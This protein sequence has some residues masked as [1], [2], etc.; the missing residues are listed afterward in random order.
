MKEDNAPIE[1][2]I[3]KGMRTM[4]ITCQ[5]EN[6]L[7]PLVILTIEITVKNTTTPIISSIAASGISVLVTG[8]FV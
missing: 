8:P 5:G 7:L 1:I 4:P 6:A 3:A 2:P